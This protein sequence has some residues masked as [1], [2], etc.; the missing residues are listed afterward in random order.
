M[1][2]ISILIG[3]LMIIVNQMTIAIESIIKIS[4]TVMIV[5]SVI[6][7]T[8]RRCVQL[9]QPELLELLEQLEILEKLEPLV[10]QEIL[11][12]LV[13]QEILESLVQQ[14]ILELL[15]QQVILVPLVQQEIL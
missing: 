2:P 4:V 6:D 10:Q 14:E 15:E 7:I 9:E 8:A 3:M 12:P 1:M 13:Q 11:E 5:T